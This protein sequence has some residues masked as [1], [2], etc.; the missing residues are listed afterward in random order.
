[1]KFDEISFSSFEPVQRCNVSW[2]PH[3]DPDLREGEPEFCLWNTILLFLYLLTMFYQIRFLAVFF[4]NNWGKMT[5]PSSSVT[6]TLGVVINDLCL[7]YPLIT[8]YLS[9]KLNEVCFD[10]FLGNYQHLFWTLT[11][12]LGTKILLVTYLLITVHL[13]VKF[14]EF[15]YAGFIDRDMTGLDLAFGNLNLVHN[16]LSYSALP[17]ISFNLPNLYQ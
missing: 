10:T 12:S 6:L 4:F 11:L 17:F 8:L 13:Y 2:S 7:A 16:T 9:V 3:C 14:G 1:M 15:A 5:W